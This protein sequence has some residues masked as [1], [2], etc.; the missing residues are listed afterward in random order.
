MSSTTFVNVLMMI[1]S[2]IS[3]YLSVAHI[4]MCYIA[5]RNLQVKSG[6]AL[7]VIHFLLS[8]MLGSR[9]RQEYKVLLDIEHVDS[10]Y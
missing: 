5:I 10:T 2:L 6:Y 9:T 3:V 7:I 4:C 1:F 8:S